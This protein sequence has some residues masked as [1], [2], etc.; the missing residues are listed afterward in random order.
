ML[1][2]QGIIECK[3][4]GAT[5]PNSEWGLA[6]CL[7][8]KLEQAKPPVANYIGHSSTYKTGALAMI[9]AY[10]KAHKILEPYAG[11]TNPSIPMSDDLKTFGFAAMEQTLRP[12][13]PTPHKIYLKP[14]ST[15][16]SEW[17]GTRIRWVMKQVMGDNYQVPVYDVE[18]YGTGLAYVANGYDLIALDHPAAKPYLDARER[19]AKTEA[20]IFFAVVGVVTGTLEVYA[21]LEVSGMAALPVIFADAQAS[22]IALGVDNIVS[23]V[24]QTLVQ[25]DTGNCIRLGIDVAI[26]RGEGFIVI[27]DKERILSRFTAPITAGLTIYDLMNLISSLQGGSGEIPSYCMPPKDG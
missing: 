2:N 13:E 16:D 21:L 25:P 7:M 11:K 9:E 22:A 14:K 12:D 23:G 4:D 18:V 24:G 3:L 26:R 15:V 8:D 17:H 5:Y 1:E 6:N 19:E 27:P 10:I 20:A